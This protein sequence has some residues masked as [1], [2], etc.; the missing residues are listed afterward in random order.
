MEKVEIP[1][2][3]DLFPKDMTMFR[4]CYFF[5][6]NIGFVI[7]EFYNSLEA[8]SQVYGLWHLFFDDIVE[9]SEQF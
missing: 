3:T 4:I 6:V 2:T 8:Y 7:Y 9:N 1:F 5:S